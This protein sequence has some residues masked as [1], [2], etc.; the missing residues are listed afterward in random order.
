MSNSIRLAVAALSLATLSATPGLGHVQS[1]GVEMGAIVGVGYGFGADV[2][3][4]DE[5]GKFAGDRQVL[6]AQELRGVGDEPH[7]R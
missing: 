2:A 3:A 1:R 6:D 4:G 5:F 7:F